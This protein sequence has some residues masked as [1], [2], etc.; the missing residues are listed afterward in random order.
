MKLTLLA[1]G[2]KP[3]R[4]VSEGFETYRKRMPRHLPVDLIEVPGGPTGKNQSPQAVRSQ[5]GKAIR[6]RIPP[7]T[8]LI[9]LE[10]KGKPWTTAQLARHLQQWQMDGSGVTF[11]IGGAEGLDPELLEAAGHQW[12]LG[13]LTLPHALVRVVV[14]E[15]LYRAWSINAN[16]PYHR[17]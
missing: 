9:A 4:W 8:N 11:L 12:S 7:N 1:V 6:S 10:V 3:P 17:A 13:P 5:E 14:A 15:Q 2:T 16:H